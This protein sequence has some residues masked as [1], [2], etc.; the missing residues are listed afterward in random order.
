MPISDLVTDNFRIEASNVTA[1]NGVLLEGESFE[2]L[3]ELFP[4]T[5]MVAYAVG[6]SL[7]GEFLTDA[8]RLDFKTAAPP[9]P[10][11]IDITVTDITTTSANVKV[12]PSLA[13]Q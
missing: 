10:V 12:K 9:A 5:D 3:D 1:L 6:I 13:E 4:N 8:L 7:Y 2:A 11:M